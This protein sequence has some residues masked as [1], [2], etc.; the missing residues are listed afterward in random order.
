M[1]LKVEGSVSE[2]RMKPINFTVLLIWLKP[3]ATVCRL[4]GSQEI[5]CPYNVKGS[6]I[7][8]VFPPSSASLPSP[9]PQPVSFYFKHRLSDLPLT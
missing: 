2:N 4:G 5:I 9:H 8:S 3:P 6:P 7:L 1:S